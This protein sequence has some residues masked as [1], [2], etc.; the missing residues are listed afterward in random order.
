MYIYEGKLGELLVEK[1]FVS[2]S[3]LGSSITMTTYI[4]FFKKKNINFY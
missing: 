2:Q 1:L 3:D 4:Y